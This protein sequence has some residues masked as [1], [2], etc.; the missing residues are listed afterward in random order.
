MRRVTPILDRR[1]ADHVFTELM[2]RRPTYLPAWNPDEGQPGTDI[3]HLGA[4]H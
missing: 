2:N 3:D 1:D 4:P